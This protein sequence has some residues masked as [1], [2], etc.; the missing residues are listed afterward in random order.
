MEFRNQEAELPFHLSAPVK[1]GHDRCRPSGLDLCAK[2]SG[3]NLEKKRCVQDG[4][5]FLVISPK[6]ETIKCK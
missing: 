6:A 3:N 2:L 1:S 5:A 4:K